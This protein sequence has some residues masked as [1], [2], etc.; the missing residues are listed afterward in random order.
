MSMNDIIYV[1]I[2][3]TIIFLGIAAYIFYLHTKQTKL[4]QDVELLEELVKSHGKRKRKPK[5]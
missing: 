4:T 3:Y 1:Y 5:K 2:A